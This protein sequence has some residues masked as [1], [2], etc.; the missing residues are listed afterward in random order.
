[1][2]NG[3]GRAA[4]RAATEKISRFQMDLDHEAAVQRSWEKELERLRGNQETGN[5]NGPS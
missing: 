2:A 4:G 3:G 5:P 1:M